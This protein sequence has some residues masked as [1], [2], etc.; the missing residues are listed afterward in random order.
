MCRSK[1][2]YL[3]NWHSTTLNAAAR[4][5][6]FIAG[7]SNDRI[8]GFDPEVSQFCRVEPNKNPSG[9]QAAYSAKYYFGAKIQ[10]R[11]VVILKRDEGGA[12]VPVLRFSA[13]CY[14]SVTLGKKMTEAVTNTL[15]CGKHAS[16]AS[17]PTKGNGCLWKN[18]K[19]T[20][21][22]CSAQITKRQCTKYKDACV[23]AGSTCA[24][25]VPT[26]FPT[27]RPTKSPTVFSCSIAETLRKC[28]SLKFKKKCLWR[29]KN[30]IERTAKPTRAPTA[31]SCSVLTKQRCRWR[32]HR[33][34]CRYDV[35]QKSC[36]ERA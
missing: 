36:V 5:K 18:R 17:C 24:D 20:D 11:D 9:L 31:F 15:L 8:N 3:R 26:P 35:K 14:N 6:V 4:A 30:C 1:V 33:K 19:C 21:F 28:R 34:L 29:D 7:I 12:F 2:R 25:R 23:F 27:R 16:K 13:N 10:Q 32:R 22:S